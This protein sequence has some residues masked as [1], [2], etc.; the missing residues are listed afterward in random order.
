MFSILTWHWI[1]FLFMTNV[2]NCKLSLNLNCIHIHPQIFDNLSTFYGNRTYVTGIKYWCFLSL[3]SSNQWVQ[4]IWIVVSL[5]NC[6]SKIFSGNIPQKFI[7]W[8]PIIFTATQN[9]IYQTVLCQEH[10]QTWLFLCSFCFPMPQL[11]PDCDRVVVLVVAPTHGVEFNHIYVVKLF[12]ML[13][14]IRRS[15][16]YWCSDIY[17]ADYGNF[18]LRHMTKVTPSLVKKFELCA[19]VSSKNI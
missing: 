1:W 14:E 18:T 7:L 9:H 2:Q 17:V 16:D 12:Q 10:S 13:M 15:E 5:F 8:S 4:K 6:D 19:I 11:T 3:F